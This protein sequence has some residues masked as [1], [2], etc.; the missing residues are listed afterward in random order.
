MQRKVKELSCQQ[1]LTQNLPIFQCTECTKAFCAEEY[2]L[3]HVQ[4]RHNPNNDNVTPT[5][6]QVEAHKLQLEIKELKERLNTTEK[7]IYSDIPK[8]A[9]DH[10]VADLQQKFELLKQHVED[11]LKLLQAQKYDQSKYERWFE[12]LLDRFG[13]RQEQALVPSGNEKVDGATQTDVEVVVCKNCLSDKR[14]Q[15]EGSGD[16]GVLNELREDIHDRLEKFE[17]ALDA[18]VSK[19]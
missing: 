17:E 14:E 16:A 8:P 13:Q 7:Q 10:P 9:N 11:E 18:R 2:L 6:F 3:A 12:S 19:S 15:N 5:P 1:A 4:R